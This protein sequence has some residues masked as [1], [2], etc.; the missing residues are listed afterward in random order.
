MTCVYSKSSK[1]RQ[2]TCKTCN[3][4]IP[5]KVIC[6]SS[7]QNFYHDSNENATESDIERKQW[8]CQNC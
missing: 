7:C 3:Y 1:K 4:V 8:H 5:V 6:C 2:C